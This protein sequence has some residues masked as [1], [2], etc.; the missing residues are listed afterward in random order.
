MERQREG[1]PQRLL[2]PSGQLI[3]IRSSGYVYSS[4]RK[5][6]ELW[7]GP[8]QGGHGAVYASIDGQSNGYPIAECDNASRVIKC[9]AI[10][11]YCYSSHDVV[12]MRVH[13]I[14]VVADLKRRDATAANSSERVVSN[15]PSSGY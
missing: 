1:L 9:V 13:D 7:W 6:A 4:F 12:E 11:G 15:G 14:R 10:L 2:L 8:Y 3:R 5:T